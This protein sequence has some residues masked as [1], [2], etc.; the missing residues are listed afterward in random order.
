MLYI[1]LTQSQGTPQQLKQAADFLSKFLPRLKQE[2]GVL[3]VYHFDR[4]DKGDDL[5]IIV[6]KDQA[7]AQA[8]R[9]GS[10]VKEAI[11]FEKANGMPATREAYPLELGLS[12]KI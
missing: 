6:W 7:A 4:P 11:A 5:T 2:P 1:T 8:Y 9:Q 12:D 10:L 3:A